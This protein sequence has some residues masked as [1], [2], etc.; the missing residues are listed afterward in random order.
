[1]ANELPGVRVP[2]ALLDRMRGA[3]APEAAA[4][5]GIAIAR[6][7]AVELRSRV[8]GLEVSTPSSQID[9]ALAV[10]DGLR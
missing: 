10:I 2:P 6:E 4:A 7:L 9:A 5:E 1:M 3:G 8:Q